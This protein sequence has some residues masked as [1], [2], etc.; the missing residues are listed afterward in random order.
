MPA[1]LK[2]I[3]EMRSCNVIF[4]IIHQFILCRFRLITFSEEATSDK[5]ELKTVLCYGAKAEELRTI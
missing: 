2:A 5:P 3:S 4:A 1:T